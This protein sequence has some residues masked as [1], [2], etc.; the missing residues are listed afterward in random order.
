MNPSTPVIACPMA[1]SEV[2]PPHPQ[3]T[4]HRYHSLAGHDMQAVLTQLAALGGRPIEQLTPAEARQQPS[5]ADAVTSLLRER[6][7]GTTPETV[8][9]VEDRT[10]PGSG[11]AID[12]RIYSPPGGGPL[13]VLL[14]IH[15]GGWVLGSLDSYDASARA[16]TNATG[17][18][19]VSTHYRLAPEH[20]FP[21]SHEDAFSAYRWVLQN[22]ASF[23]GDPQRI[24][25]AGESAGGNMAVAVSLMAREHGVA[26]P[27][28]QLLIYPVANTDT[29][30]TSFDENEHAM[31]LNKAMMEW[32]ARHEFV[33]AGD[34]KDPRIDLLHADLQGLPPATIITAAIDPLRSGGKALA[35]ALEAA[36][37]EV[38][39]KC[40]DGV[41]H[42]FFGMGAVVAE[43]REATRMAAKNL[44]R[45]FR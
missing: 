5:P 30:T 42:E 9:T 18:I 37:V 33:H 13:P 34:K 22:T 28:H 19:V 24:A 10:I 44:R 20:P 14:Y 16:L 4:P 3:A 23:Q 12:I 1:R 27:V 32:F 38:D 7:L 29:N 25:I 41:T 17:A 21:A 36:G 8:A 31:P 35:D 2:Q 39:Y 11:G 26:L 6:G 15:G 40:Y 43:S 45:A